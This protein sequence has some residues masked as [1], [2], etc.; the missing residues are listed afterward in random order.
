MRATPAPSFAA[1]KRSKCWM[2]VNEDIT[3]RGDVLVFRN[4]SD[5]AR[6][7]RCDLCNTPL[8]MDYEW[9]VPETILLVNPQWIYEGEDGK[10]VV[11]QIEKEFSMNGGLADLDVCWNS[12]NDPCSSTTKVSYLGKEDVREESLDEGVE[13]VKKRG[14]IQCQDL[15]W[16]G[17]K[18]DAGS[19]S[20]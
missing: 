18:L 11:E 12:R 16:T 8:V 13:G 3:E 4:S 17:Y 14:I 20:K 6:R 10:E 1:V 15:D 9:F 5:F 7:G 2:E 19:V